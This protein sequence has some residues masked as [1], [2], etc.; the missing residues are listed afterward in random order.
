MAIEDTLN[1]I[2]AKLDL[3]EKSLSK[4]TE[5]KHT[6]TGSLSL[7][8]EAVKPTPKANSIIRNTRA[9]Q[10]KNTQAAPQVKAPVAATQ[11]MQSTE[12]II[13]KYAP[14]ASQLNKK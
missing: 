4:S 7:P 11:P 13:K 5:S 14:N 10:P 2:L 6:V 8:T 12:D 1:A 3:I 9:I